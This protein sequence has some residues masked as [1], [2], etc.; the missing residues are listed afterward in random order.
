MKRTL[1]TLLFLIHIELTIDYLFLI[2][3]KETI[4][5]TKSGDEIGNRKFSA[6]FQ[7]QFCFSFLS[8]MSSTAKSVRKLT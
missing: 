6:E 5:S 4:A 3:K 1:T 2:H 8:C 7:V